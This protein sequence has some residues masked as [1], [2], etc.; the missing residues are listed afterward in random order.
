MKLIKQLQMLY[1]VPLN[2]KIFQLLISVE[3]Y[4]KE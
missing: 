1:L 4:Q 3:F 2:S